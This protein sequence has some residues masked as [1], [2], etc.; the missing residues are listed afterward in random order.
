[1]GNIAGNIAG[2]NFAETSQVERASTVFSLKM[3][4][5]PQYGTTSTNYVETR[6]WN[7]FLNIE[8][9][10]SSEQM[11][12]RCKQGTRS[13]PLLALTLQQPKRREER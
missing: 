12:Q 6:S 11:T 3:I 8:R 10:E 5:G 4:K 9:S 2:S 7:N 13:S 1:M